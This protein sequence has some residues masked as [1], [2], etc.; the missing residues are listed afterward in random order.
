MESKYTKRL[1]NIFPLSYKVTYDKTDPLRQLINENGVTLEKGERQ[2]KETLGGYSINTINPLIAYVSYYIYISD[3]YD[4]D[5]LNIELE[6]N[7]NSI[8]TNSESEFLSNKVTGFDFEEEIIPNIPEEYKNYEFIGLLRSFNYNNPCWILSLK[9]SDYY[10][11]YN[12]LSENP[13]LKLYTIVR[14]NY[15]NFGEDEYLNIL[16]ELDDEG[17]IKLV[18]Y[19]KYTP[20]ANVEL[21]DTQNLINPSNPD[22]DGLKIKENDYTIEGNKI[23]FNDTR[24]DYN[25]SYDLNDTNLFW[26]TMEDA[27]LSSTS[28]LSY[29]YDKSWQIKM[30]SSGLDVIGF[31]KE[32]KYIY[33]TLDK[34]GEIYTDY[35]FQ[36]VISNGFSVILNAKLSQNNDEVLK[37]SFDNETIYLGVNNDNKLVFRS[38]RIDEA[39]IDTNYDLCNNFNTYFIIYENRFY[40]VYING[41]LID[42]FEIDSNLEKINNITYGKTTPNVNKCTDI[43]F[44]KS[45]L[46]SNDILNYTNYFNKINIDLNAK[47]LL[48]QTNLIFDADNVIVNNQGYVTELKSIG[49]DKSIL[50]S[51]ID[52]NDLNNIQINSN[53]LNGNKYLS[54][55]SN[56][57]ISL[58]ST[59]TNTFLSNK[60]TIIAV[61]RNNTNVNEY[62]SIKYQTYR[63]NNLAIY[64]DL[65]YCKDNKYYDVN[66]NYSNEYN[67]NNF[68]ISI[69][70]CGNNTINFYLNNSGNGEFSSSISNLATDGILQLTGNGDLAYFAILNRKITESEVFNI[71]QYLAYK[72]DLTIS[73]KLDTSYN[74]IPEIVKRVGPFI[75]NKTFDNSLLIAEYDVKLLH[76][77]RYLT[78]PIK[79]F[80][81][82]NSEA[83]VTN[84]EDN[85]NVV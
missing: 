56:T 4:I 67:A 25:P 59:Q 73:N 10:L 75:N 35:N 46:N 1:T 76:P 31:N 64:G 48:N 78:S 65:G 36:F 61:H 13:E 34:F 53:L 42:T 37:I 23:L 7:S 70:T 69:I 11:R 20:F 79:F 5:T 63:A 24:S 80:D 33:N 84:N 83:V 29:I 28:N 44:F 18:A 47:E 82:N 60:Y 85:N 51:T 17:N 19:L 6:E 66:I 12:K 26:F 81:L 2:L 55:L 3:L 49:K 43:L 54:F 8:I 72:F 9:D 68:N 45:V 22:S 32:D 41:Q 38:D 52:F 77:L 27:V 58:L 15:T 74:N 40:K 50:E 39:V 57:S 30:F 71:N 62:S 16:P 21:I 14:K